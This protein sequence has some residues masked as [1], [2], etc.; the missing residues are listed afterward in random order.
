MLLISH[1]GNINSKI[2]SRENNPN[3]IDEAI[4]K[5][6]DV[7]VDVWLYKKILYFGH[8]EPQYIID[9]SWIIKRMDKLWLHCKNVES[10]EY[11]KD[12]D[13]PINYFWHQQD[14]FTITSLGYFWTYPGKPLTKNSI[15]VLPENAH[16]E[17]LYISKGICSDYIELYRRFKSSE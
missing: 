6:Y 13:Y 16:Y 11:L 7:E 2:E 10:L 4:A 9:L 15:A 14:D 17:N 8:D 12:L 5:G 3:Y 1:R